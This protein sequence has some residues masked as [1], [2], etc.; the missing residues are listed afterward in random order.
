MAV[1]LLS[2]HTQR[3]RKDSGGRQWRRRNESR[4]SWVILLD[5]AFVYASY[6]TSMSTHMCV[7]VFLSVSVCADCQVESCSR[8]SQLRYFQTSAYSPLP[9]PTPVDSPCFKMHDATSQHSK[10]S[11]RNH[12]FADAHECMHTDLICLRL[13]LKLSD[14]SPALPHSCEFVPASGLHIC[15]NTSLW[16]GF[17]HCT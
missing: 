10:L 9:L 13:T 6:Q 11:K 15:I 16:F 2:P 17:S 8:P 4:S 5:L 7:C 12:L 1:R 3:Q 14:T